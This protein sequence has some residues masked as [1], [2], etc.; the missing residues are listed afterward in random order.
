M[1]AAIFT[2][3][4]KQMKVLIAGCACTRNDN[5]VTGADKRRMTI[6]LIP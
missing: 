5:G 6:K 1:A 3:K 2:N 4:H